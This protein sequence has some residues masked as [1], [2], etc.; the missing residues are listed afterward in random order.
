MKNFSTKIKRKKWLKILITLLIVFTLP[1]LFAYFSN[2]LVQNTAL[3]K[4]FDRL[5]NIE[6]NE[7]GVV[8]GTAKYR[9]A[10]GI[11]L[12]FKYRIDAAVRLFNS[13]K[14]NFIL[15]SGDNSTK[16]YN[17]PE[18]FKQ[19][20]IKRGVPEDKIFLDYAGFRTLDSVVRAKKVFGQKKFTIISQ[21]FH[22][23]RAV[24]LA[25]HY[26]IEAIAYNAKDVSVNYGFKTQVREYFA[27]SKAVLDVVFNV[28][29][30]FLGD[31]IVIE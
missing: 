18:A 4:T 2:K 23:E 1:I 28:N 20:L 31:K 8:L 19:E 7:V 13:G 21:K 30:K 14:I 6:F 29:P 10:G 25:E 3:N 26:D 12:Y 5:E 16:Y 17:E 27:R 24:Y 22:N 15:V 11:N 9:A